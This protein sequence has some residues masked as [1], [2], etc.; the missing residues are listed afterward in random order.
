MLRLRSLLAACLFFLSFQAAAQYSPLGQGKYPSLLWEITGKGLKKPS[1]LFGTMHISHKLVFHLSDSFYL[2][3]KGADVVALETDPGAWQDDFSRYDL[4]G[5]QQGERL[6][7]RGPADY[8]HISQLRAVPYEPLLE[9]GMQFTP[10]LLNSFLYRTMADSRSEFEEDT[11]LDLYIYQIGRKWGKRLRG[12]E[13]FDESIRLMKEAYA[14]AARDRRARSRSFDPDNELT[15]GRLGEAYRSGNLDL[16]DTIHKLNSISAAFDEKFLYRRNEIQADG[17][18]SLLRSGV[19][20]FAGVGAAH[21][22]GQRGVIELL[23]SKGYR[24]RP[25]RMKE[26]NSRYK[27][28]VDRLRVPLRFQTQTADDGAFSVSTPGRLYPYGEAVDG[29]RQ[30][31]YAD[32]SNGSY[33]LVVR[34]ATGAGRLGH[35]PQQVQRS[36]DSLLYENIPGKILQKRALLRNGYS[37]I[38]VVSRTRRGDHQRHQFFITPFEVLLFRV[39][40]SG[41]Y[42][43][44]GP[45]AE[46]FFSSIQLRPAASTSWKTYSPPSG[47][48][49]VLMP[50]EPFAY[51]EQDWNYAA[52]DRQTNSYYTIIQSSIHHHGFAGEDSVDLQLMEES[53]LSSPQVNRPLA[54]KWGLTGG[55]ASLEGSYRLQ[56]SSVALIKFLVRGPHYYTVMAVAPRPHARMEA[57]LQSFVPRPFRY[58]KPQLRQDTLL[59]YTVQSA[60]PLRKERRQA[61]DGSESAYFDPSEDEEP[62]LPR[63]E[64]QLV[65]NDSTGEAIFVSFYRAS[66][67]TFLED[68]SI[69]GKDGFPRINKRW[70]VWSRKALTLPD[71]TR[72]YDYE[73]GDPKSSRLF[74]CRS[75]RKG[76]TRYVLVVQGDTLRNWSSFVD[77]FFTTFNPSGNDVGPNPFEKK[78]GVFFRDLFSTDSLVRK[79]ALNSLSLVTFDTTDLPQLRAAYERLSS[80][81]RGYLEL[82]TGFVDVL[83]SL[84]SASS[85][86]WLREIYYAAGDTVQLQHAALSALLHQRS[87]PAYK[88]FAELMTADPPV[89]DE[90]S[91]EIDEEGDEEE[92]A[93][94]TVIMRRTDYSP[95]GS[96]FME[97]L[98]DSLALTRTI[99]PELLPLLTVSDY[100]QP[101]KRLLRRMI[102]S[103]L[104]SAAEYAPYFPKL[105]IEARQELKR[106]LIGEKSRMIERMQQKEDR[107]AFHPLLRSGVNEPDPGNGR[108]LLQATLLLPFWEKEAAVPLF[109]RQLL[110]VSDRKVR[111]STAML[112]LRHGRPL[113]DS[114]LRQLAADDRYRYPLY[115][116]LWRRKALHLFPAAY[117]SA[118]E[119]APSEIIDA[120]ERAVPDSLVF[121]E[122]LPVTVEGISGKVYC[123]KYRPRRDDAFWIV[124]FAGLVPS[125][126]NYLFS[127]DTVMRY[128]QRLNLTESTGKKLKEDQPLRPQ[129]QRLLQQTIL[130]RQPAAARFFE[131]ERRRFISQE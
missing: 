93:G 81:D 41:D 114:V 56:D 2:A 100:E 64:E 78:S 30:L 113:P 122:E 4:E 36:L 9:L 13:N 70:T 74:R 76:G 31:H 125:S 80:K 105:L 6:N 25:I 43:L 91:I 79:K 71:S 69:M 118:K 101:M 107:A 12:L 102:D 23:R 54:R 89:L 116:D 33:Y 7:S 119:L 16:L 92:G 38:E 40:G 95:G 62:E 108:L 86:N 10:Q 111:Y 90:E 88:V 87:E 99:L 117:A 66:R 120:M 109:F 123:F 129:L 61:I 55:Y 51:G 126:G 97:A 85:V 130:S 24:L 15:P 20:V 49:E 14:D 67:Y 124:A 5:L 98:Q 127:L 39:S 48:F 73:L 17:V 77:T 82:K 128:R 121:L 11:Y 18:D 26:R 22:P 3:L 96:R 53:F 106:Q 131:G 60:V 58:G 104:L 28:L 65:R 84:P 47:G 110:G 45:E 112:L 57:F 19:S 52:Y 83:G 29:F 27:E 42:I 32:M 21:L 46:Q 59:Q 34:M 1:Y 94:R 63:S 115:A 35:S 103:S 37:G 50:H 68:S 44:R 72:I 75:I 8:L